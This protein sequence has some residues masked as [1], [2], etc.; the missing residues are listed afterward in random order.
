MTHSVIYIQLLV[1]ILYLVW[2]YVIITASFAEHKLFYLFLGSHKNFGHRGTVHNIIKDE[3]PQ[4]A[5]EGKSSKRG[6]AVHGARE[7][8]CNVSYSSYCIQLLF[9]KQLL[10]LT[11]AETSMGA[12]IVCWFLVCDW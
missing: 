1:V 2:L 11:Y 3:I 9:L 8:C 7:V 5:S 12:E 4:N 10:W 6:I